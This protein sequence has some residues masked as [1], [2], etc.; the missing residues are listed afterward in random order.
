[1]F[2]EKIDIFVTVHFLVGHDSGINF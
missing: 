1:M 2:L